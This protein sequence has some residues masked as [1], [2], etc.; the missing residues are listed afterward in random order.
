MESEYEVHH[1]DREL[2]IRIARET[3]EENGLLTEFPPEV[4]A[5][6]EQINEPA[7]PEGLPNIHDLR[8]F[9]W[10]SID[11][12]DSKD[13]DQMTVAEALSDDEVRIYVAIADV[14][15]LVKKDSAIDRYARYNT[16]TVYHPAINFPM[17]PEKLSTNLT[18]LNPNE[19]RMAVVCEFTV[20]S[21]GTV[22]E[23]KIYRAYV[24]NHAQLAYNSVAAWLEGQAEMPSALATVEGL[25][26][27]IRLQ[28]EVAQKLRKKR[29]LHGALTLQTIQTIPIFDGDEVVDLA[30][31][32][33]N[34]A[35]ELIEDFMI[36]ANSV[37]AGFLDE[38]KFPALRRV[39]RI[40][41]RWDRIV[42]LAEQYGYKLS[43]KPD[44]KA[45]NEFLIK[46]QQRDP[47]R[48]P[49][50]SL[51]VIK[52]LGS[53]EYVAEKPGEK[54]P[55]HFSLS[56][57]DYT[58]STAPNRRYPDLVTQRLIKAALNHEEP[59]YS[60]EELD[61]L[62]KHITAQEDLEAKIE[63]KTAKAAAALVL[64]NHIGE[65]FNGFITGAS[66]KGYWVRI[67][68]IPVEGKLISGFSGLDVGDRV[69]VVLDSVDVE[70]GF[71]DFKRLKKR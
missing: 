26:E 4:I 39:V 9:L 62:A 34:L 18:S 56:V 69:Q 71:I 60:F 8:H 12:D 5:E 70:K 10:A 32:K 25:A 29:Y 50:L 44:S 20:D 45:L 47:L 31:D 67:L 6:L 53:G 11:N 40:P 23:P 35:K 1:N 46:E 66:E 68:E 51:T 38:C 7:K 16:A 59:P 49:D 54:A 14:D 15:S 36:A 57:K 3:M 19:D 58:H 55:G 21:E 52:L 61:E 22:C 65:T 17:L 13:L 64:E 41:K 63:R 30:I 37:S 48:F 28:N 42:D 24:R 27:N 33:P 2:L 43:R